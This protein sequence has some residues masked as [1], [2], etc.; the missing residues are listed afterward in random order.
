MDQKRQ[1]AR[2]SGFYDWRCPFEE[3][4]FVAQINGS[5]NGLV[6]TLGGPQS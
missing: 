2:N 5:G 1:T 6:I 3:A 4:R